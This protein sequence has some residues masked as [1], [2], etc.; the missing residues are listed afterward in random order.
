MKKIISK[1]K[2]DKK[3][4]PAYLLI[5]I[6]FVAF[7]PDSG[8]GGFDKICFTSWSNYIF[9]NG[10]QN[11]Y[12]FGIDYLPIFQYILFLYGK[13]QGTAENVVLNINSLKYVTLLF[14]VFSAYLVYSFVK[15]KYKTKESAFLATLF[16]L[17]NIAY[18]YNNV[19][20]GQVDGIYTCMVFISLLYGLKKK[21]SLSVFF[22]VLAINFKLQAIIFL[23]LIGLLIFPEIWNNLS[24]KNIIIWLTPV[25]ILQILILLPF[26]IS[27]DLLILLKVVKSSMGKYPKVSMGAFNVWYLFFEDPNQIFDKQG[28][29]GRSY[30]KYGL[31]AFSISLFFTIWLLIKQTFIILKG[32]KYNSIPTEKIILMAT[33]TPLVFFYFNT[34]MHSRYIHPAI[35]FGGVYALY[36]KRPLAFVLLSIAYF[37]NIENGSKLLKSDITPY[38]YFFFQPLFVSCI[39]VI[40][41][42]VL[43]YELYRKPKDVE[44]N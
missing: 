41:I 10:L 2:E 37:L 27:G 32:K 34:Q 12:K 19:I 4:I 22:I 31:L 16:I 20:Y 43:L 5:L 13:T 26:I 39:F 1:I 29:F 3:I 14:D 18:F 35:L 42:I 8:P 23:P 11:I 30:N 15:T 38:T 25:F 28:V 36:T 7:M 21:I 9:A 44:R 24:F 6:L 33:L 17:L 40:A